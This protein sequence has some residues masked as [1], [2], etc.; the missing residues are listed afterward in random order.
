MEK[1][2]N[3]H[4]SALKAQQDEQARAHAEEEEASHQGI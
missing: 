2:W 4:L 3:D 1:V